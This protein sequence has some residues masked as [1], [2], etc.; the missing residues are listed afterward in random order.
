MSSLTNAAVLEAP[1]LP[2][3][4]LNRYIMQPLGK[5]VFIDLFYNIAQKVSFVALALIGTFTFLLSSSAITV[6]S[7]F[8]SLFIAIPSF[9]FF[10]WAAHA[11]TSARKTSSEESAIES[12]IIGYLRDKSE[13]EITKEVTDFFAKQNWNP[14]KIPQNVLEALAKINPGKDPLYSLMPL[15]LRYK[16]L[17]ENNFPFYDEC[18]KFVPE[19]I[20]KNIEQK[21]KELAGKGEPPLTEEIKDHYRNSMRETMYMNIEFKALQDRFVMAFVLKAIKDPTFNSTILEVGRFTPRTFTARN[22][23]PINDHYFVF[24]DSTR[25]PI[26]TFQQVSADPTVENIYEL[27]FKEKV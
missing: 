12:Y 21:D 17:S 16:Y 9:L 22:Y 3:I 2:S 19:G 25:H 18:K 15:I 27:L 8:L 10:F 20:E 14:Q 24:N 7:P 23:E 13:S 1:P 11:T 6:T 4:T 26:I 5:A